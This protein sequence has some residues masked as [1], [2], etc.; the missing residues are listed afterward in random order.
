MGDPGPRE[1]VI[2]GPHEAAKAV[3]QRYKDGADVI[4]I[5]ATGGVLSVAKDGQGPQFTQEEIIDYRLTNGNRSIDI[6]SL[7]ICSEAWSS[8]QKIN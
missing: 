2:N 3:R 4:K 7:K 6:I 5:T 8:K 1:G